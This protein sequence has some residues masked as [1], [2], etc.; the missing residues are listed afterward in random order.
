VGKAMRA[1]LLLAILGTLVGACLADPQLV[2]LDQ[3]QSTLPS[4]PRSPIA[5]DPSSTD[6]APAV[7]TDASVGED[8]SVSPEPPPPPPPPPPACPPAGSPAGTACC[9]ANGAPPPCIGLACSHCDDCLDKGCAAGTI[10]CA[11]VEGHDKT[12]KSMSCRV[13]AQAGACPK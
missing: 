3:A 6:A 7:D 9:G 8:G 5:N 11:T 4:T 13:A 1:A 2:P 10:C 12:Y